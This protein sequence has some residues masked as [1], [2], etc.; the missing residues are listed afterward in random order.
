MSLIPFSSGP[1]YISDK[2]VHFLFYSISVFLLFLSTRKRNFRNLLLIAAAVF[3]YSFL[4]EVIQYFLPFR[5]F[6]FF[7]LLANLSGIVFSS[8]IIFGLGLKQYKN[9]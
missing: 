5:S 6:S 7:D 4:I 3:F 9:L 1:E 2:L 8:V